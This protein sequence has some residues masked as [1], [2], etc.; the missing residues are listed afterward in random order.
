MAEH[1]RAAFHKCTGIT[2]AVEAWTIPGDE[3]PAELEIVASAEFASESAARQWAW[4][5]MNEGYAARLWLR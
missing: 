4:D 5:R 1:N 2:Y 3:E